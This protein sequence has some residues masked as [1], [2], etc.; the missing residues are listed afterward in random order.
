MEVLLELS[1][2][3]RWK[4]A[5]YQSFQHLVKRVFQILEV[6]W[7]TITSEETIKNTT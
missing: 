2:N 7:V 5:G 6:R 3:N 4:N 1:A